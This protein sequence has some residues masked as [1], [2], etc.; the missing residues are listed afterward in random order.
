MR[1]VRLNTP[2]SAASDVVR[3]LPDNRGVLLRTALLE[4]LVCVHRS[5]G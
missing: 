2:S 1:K 5:D 3:T 4:R